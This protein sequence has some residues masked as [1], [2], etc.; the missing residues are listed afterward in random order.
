MNRLAP[1]V[2][3]K[4]NPSRDR[5]LAR[6]VWLCPAISLVLGGVVLILLGVNW[7][8]AVIAAALLGC[9]VAAVWTII[10]NRSSKR[11]IERVSESHGRHLRDGECPLE[12]HRRGGSA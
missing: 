8:A 10:A 9:L 11:A 4:S 3:E 12:S 2:S 6:G 7:R 5:R 1:V